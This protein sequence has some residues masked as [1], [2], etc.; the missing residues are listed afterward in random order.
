MR[1]DV[2]LLED[3]ARPLGPRSRVRLHLG[4]SE[5]GA[6]VVVP[7]P[8][9]E[10]GER[11][12]ARIVVD[13]P[14]VARAGDR[15][16]LRGGSPVATVGGGVVI[17]PFA[18]ARS[19]GWHDV[20]ASPLENLMRLLRDAGTAGVVASDLPVRLGL[21]PA[22][23]TALMRASKAWCVEERAYAEEVRDRV[24]AT[25][26]ETLG[27]YHR[28][29]PL[30][31]V[32]PRQWLRSRVRAPQPV[33]DDIIHR[34]ERAGTLVADHGGVRLAEFTAVMSAPQRAVADL[35]LARLAESGSEPPTLE[36][37][38]RVISVDA[39]GLIAIC[40]ALG[41]EG[42]VVAVEPDRYF[43]AESVVHLR[44]TLLCGMSQNTDYGPAELRDLIGLTR[45]FL[46]PFLEYC[47][48]EGY[49][50]RDGLGRRRRGM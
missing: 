49:T 8:S 7:G 46:I 10:P 41:R 40:R 20:G 16:V 48:R 21:P 35:V 15:F 3:A 6:R 2:A 39:D 14:I 24:R 31:D 38:S 5:V 36:E 17:D 26:I 32:A 29:R 33:I 18:S 45:K 27:E 12:P 25:I 30:D 23:S 19:R 11:R 50:V 44:E 34:L 42:R 22:E 37:L 28:A 1:A 13:G 4:T 43:L 47:D 9:L